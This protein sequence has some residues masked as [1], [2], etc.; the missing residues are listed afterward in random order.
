MA[1]DEAIADEVRSLCAPP[2]L[3]LYAWNTPSVSLGVFQPFSDIDAAYCTAHAIP[4][5]RRPTG[6]RAILHGDELTYSFSA[7]AASPSFGKTLRDAATALS[8]AFAAAFRRAGIDAIVRSR[9]APGQVLT[10]SALCFQS[11]SYGE[12]T[13]SGT[14]I[15][16]SAQKRWPNGFLQQ[17][18]IPYVMD[19]ARA[20]AVFMREES[21]I[22]RT[23]LKMLWDGFDAATLQVFLVEAFEET[24]AIRLEEAPPSRQELAQAEH[25]AEQK[26]RSP[27]WTEARDR[28][29]RLSH[30]TGTSRQT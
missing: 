17:G 18:S 2:T 19:T 16:G 6:G 30:N 29:R 11:V 20:A 26:Y 3:R 12:F 13:V 15:I 21:C 28:R 14:K 1:L 24:F 5:V 8:L 9:P 23:G 27:A 7:P 10:R 25:L 22:D 4:I